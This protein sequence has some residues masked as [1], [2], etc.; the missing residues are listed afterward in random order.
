MKHAVCFGILFSFGALNVWA[1]NQFTGRILDQKSKE[2]IVGASVKVLDSFTGT[3]SDKEG[4]FAIQ[5]TQ[6]MVIVELSSLGYLPKKDTLKMGID[7]EILLQFSP[8][9]LN[10]VDIHVIPLRVGEN[11]PF[12]KTEWTAKDIAPLNTG[13]DLPVLLDQT[14]GTVV[15][16]DAGNGVGYTGLRIRGSDITRINV[17]FDGI[18]VNDPESQAVFWVN[19]PDIAGSAQSIQIQRGVG[20]ST[21]GGGAFGAGI[22]LQT[23]QQ[24]LKPYG[25]IS[26]SYGSFNTYKV[27]LSG[28]SGLLANR[29]TV[30]VRAS[31][32]SSDGYIDRAFSNLQSLFG[33][34]NYL[35]KK[36][37]LRFNVFTGKEKTYQAWNGVPQA[38]ADSIPTY[39]ESG[40]EKPGSPYAN[41][42]DNYRQDYYRLFF[43]HRFNENINLQAATF[44]T[45]G[46]GHY[47]QYKADV[48][49]ADYALPP[50]ISGQDT[51][52]QSDIIRQLAL[53]NYFYG[54]TFSVQYEKN[55]V[56]L[57]A[58][59]AWLAYD[60]RHYGDVIWASKGM[61]SVSH[62]YYYFPAFKNEAN[63][64][65]KLN[66]RVWKEMY[67]FADLQY[68]Y[69]NYKVHGFRVN[70]TLK[71]DFHWNFVNPK[72]G[73]LYRI[74]PAHTLFASFAMGNK[75]P[76]RDDLEAGLAQ[77]PTPETLYDTELGYEFRKGKVSTSATLYYMHYKNQLIQ[78]GKINDVG[79]YTRINV[80]VSYRAGIELTAKARLHKVI[81]IG[82][83]LA[84]SQNRIKEFVEYI[85]DYDNGGQLETI[86][87][88]SSIAFSPSWVG[89]FQ[90]NIVPVKGFA[91]DITGKGVSRQYLDNTQ[92][93][94]RSLKG[95]FTADLRLSYHLKV[96]D[97]A[98]ISFFAN[99]FNVT[100]TSYAP[101]GYTYGYFWGG[102][103]T[104]VN[105]VYPMAGIHF[106]GGVTIR[107]EAP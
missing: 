100:N 32:I 51:N 58:G 27:A 23:Q 37:S 4:R 39:N 14:P 38:L 98:G 84:F 85:D 7:K 67:V 34:V 59:G 30:D 93:L 60:G 26:A 99:A 87:K 97:W 96:K 69:V 72:A 94:S 53:D 31:K 90:I 22:N 11:D 95:F 46:K 5:S 81:S 9:L 61:D 52:Y 70:P 49:Y 8:L 83:N 13:K 77:V 80:P 107:L 15:F 18:P 19:T 6:N 33:S 73:I 44:L 45:R 88:N 17:T 2:P 57:K 71:G 64:Y 50:Q 56:N 75:E 48:D 82:A 20:T 1:Q 65:A 79:A 102:E 89:G 106:N 101:N 74:N 24:N 76:N 40:M 63:I 54:A 92:Q 55:R 43:T 10:K 25:E 41:E 62:R 21:T 105:Y 91:I 68:R 29:F 104:D 103:R 36:T 66:Y 78:T 47:E 12:V 86:Y 35:G 3:S 28:G 16:S 42:T